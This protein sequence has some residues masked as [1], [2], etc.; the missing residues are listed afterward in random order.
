MKHENHTNITQDDIPA[1]GSKP[2]SK[3]THENKNIYKFEQK[4]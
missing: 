1:S 4:M 3:Y 2:R